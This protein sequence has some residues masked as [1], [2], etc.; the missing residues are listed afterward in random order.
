MNTKVA[1]IGNG[2]VG[3]SMLKLFPNAFVY[4]R[5][6]AYNS[7]G[8]LV[9]GYPKDAWEELYKEEYKK[10]VNEADIAFVCVP[11][12]LDEVTGKLD[13]SVVEEVVAWC[14]ATIIVIRS[15]VNPGDCET[16]TTKYGKRIVFQPEYLGE[17]AA[18]PLLNEK[19]TKFIILG[20]NPYDTRELINLYA[21]VYNAN[22]KIRQVTLYEAE[23]IKISEN[24]AIAFKVM[25]CQELYDA[26][27]KAGIDY[28]TIR[29]AVYGDDPRF[30]LYWT[31]I[32]PDNRGFQSS[33]CLKKD[34][35]AWAAWAESLGITPV[36]TK[37]LVEKS[38]EYA[39]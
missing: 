24:R 11:T 28:Y 20:G 35:P 9:K 21:L 3:G 39:E 13:T 8:D 10:N 29:D 1:I 12:P 31:F 19:K 32:Y 15:T 6:F 5:G 38:K 34:V 25:Q 17:T 27:E 18:H 16:W 14:E 37:V 26:C 2:W 4:S 36:L 7:D 30:T 23:V 22:T 33:K